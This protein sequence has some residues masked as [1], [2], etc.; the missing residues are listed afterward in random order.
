MSWLY[1]SEVETGHETETNDG[2]RHGN[3]VKWV[4]F[5][6][7]STKHNDIMTS[8]YRVH[9]SSSGICFI[10]L[11]HR[12][13]SPKIAIERRVFVLFTQASVSPLFHFI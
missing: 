5:L 12:L 3:I 7:F 1:S 13:R 4:T 6:Q 10:N 2:I 8:W 9:S 11:S